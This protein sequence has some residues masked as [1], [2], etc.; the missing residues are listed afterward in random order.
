[1]RGALSPDSRSAV[2]IAGG[3]GFQVRALLVLVIFVFVTVLL[4]TAWLSDDAYITFRTVD[5]FLNGHGLRWNVA[6]RVQSYTHPLWMFGV[7]GLV[8]LTREFY[9]TV[10]SAS[11][12]LS[13]VAAWVVASRV[14][15]SVNAGVLA[16]AMLVSSKAFV[17]YSTSGLENPLSH[18]LLAFFAMVLFR[19]ER[20]QR[21]NWQT[22]RSLC[23]LAG[24]CA[25]TRLDTIL[26]V[27]PPLG[28]LPGNAARARARQPGWRRRQGQ[29][30]RTGRYCGQP[31]GRPGYP[32]LCHVVGSCLGWTLGTYPRTAQSISG[33][34][35]PAANRWRMEAGRPGDHR[36]D[37]LVTKSA[38]GSGPDVV[39][40]HRFR[41]F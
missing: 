22:L 5:N 28:C 21:M 16:I 33:Q 12:A 34:S 18:L 30:R 7:A 23:M 37:S 13:A 14:S 11:V 3:A 17:D 35:S 27:L 1:M 8:A 15:H 25:F 24:L 41:L 40:Y 39:S 29:G 36:R 32:G 38:I 2:G 26:L 4:R 10:V 9:F 6:E 19:A 31:R 20:D